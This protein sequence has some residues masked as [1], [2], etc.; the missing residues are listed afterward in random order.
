[1]MV[2][3]LY[4]Q[5]GDNEPPDMSIRMKRAF[6][7]HGFRKD[8]FDALKTGGFVHEAKAYMEKVFGREY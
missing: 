8:I 7:K 2:F 5:H 1:M 6:M 4:H 3:F